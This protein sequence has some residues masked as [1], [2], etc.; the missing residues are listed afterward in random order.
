MAPKWACIVSSGNITVAFHSKC[1]AKSLLLL[2]CKRKVTIDFSDEN[3][4]S[5]H[6]CETTDE[7]ISYTDI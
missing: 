4:N 7:D 3:C 2:L 6:F 1:L 5:L